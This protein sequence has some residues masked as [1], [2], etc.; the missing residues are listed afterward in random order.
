MLAEATDKVFSWGKC[1][2]KAINKRNSNMQPAYE[3]S[4]PSAPDFASFLIHMWEKPLL[5]NCFSRQRD[6]GK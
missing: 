5:I 3:H 6:L 1:H 4:R 2:N